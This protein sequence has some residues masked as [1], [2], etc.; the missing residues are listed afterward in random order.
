MHS[1]AGTFSACVKTGVMATE[2]SALPPQEYIYFYIKILKMLILVLT[3]SHNI[4]IVTVLLF[5]FKKQK[6]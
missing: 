5:S 6:I 3:M 1:F 2:N 4:T